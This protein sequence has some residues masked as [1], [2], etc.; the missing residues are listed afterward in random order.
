MTQ[1]FRDSIFGQFLHLV[2]G[3]K[4]VP[5]EEQKNPSLWQRRVLDGKSAARDKEVGTTNLASSAESDKTVVVPSADGDD[6]A[7][8]EG[9]TSRA[10]AEKGV[11]PNLVD[12]YGP[13]DPE[14]GWLSL[15]RT[16]L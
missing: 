1:L 10:T 15:L 13:Q 8:S 4:L 7:A 2:S 6:D 12:W 16:W 3:G 11:D 14:V 9:S 5:S